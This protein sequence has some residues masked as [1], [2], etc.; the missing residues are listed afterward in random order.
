MSVPTKPQPAKLYAKIWRWHFYAGLCVAPILVVIAATGAL[1]IFRTELER[2]LYPNT[3][4]VNPAET[5]VSFEA[6]LTAARSFGPKDSVA[7]GFGIDVDPT[8][9]TTVFLRTESGRNLGVY[10]DPYSGKVL[11]DETETRFFGIL[12]GV[13]RELFVGAVGGIVKELVTCWTI[14]LLLSGAYLWWPRK[15]RPIWGVWL[16]RLRAHPHIVFRDLHAMTGLYVWCVALTIACTGL[17]YSTLWGSGYRLAERMEKALGSRKPP[18]KPPPSCSSPES[19]DLP[20][21]EI[22]AIAKQN[23]P[24]ACITI[25]FPRNRQGAVLVLPNWQIGPTNQRVLFLDRAT[26]EV[27][28]DRSNRPS[29]IVE[30]W[31][32]W[33]FPLHVGSVFGTSSKVIWLAACLGLIALPVTGVW[34]WWQRRPVGQ[35]GL[36]PRP[37]SSATPR[38]T[39]VILALCILLPMFGISIVAILVGE[40]TVRWRNH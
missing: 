23:L 4:F 19:P 3:L 20:A 29:G 39:V 12:L 7:G 25:L 28:Q 10:V 17:A 11:G 38:L 8:R 34:M 14:V 24:G 18:P 22:V 32:T 16:P 21:D 30:W 1:L 15:G 31:L 40:R 13:H 2:F 36:P 33:N 26:G 9:A 35:S 27:L 5:R 6:Q 37:S